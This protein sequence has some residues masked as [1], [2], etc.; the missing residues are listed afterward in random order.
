MYLAN[1]GHC[2][3]FG[4]FTPTAPLQELAQVNIL[5]GNLSLAGIHCVL[6]VLVY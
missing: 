2:G 3:D 5:F 6:M 1:G 4:N